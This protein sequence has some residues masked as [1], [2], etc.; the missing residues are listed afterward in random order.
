MGCLGVGLGAS[1]SCS[2]SSK[3]NMVYSMLN[4][5]DGCLMDLIKNKMSTIS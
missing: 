2:T 3:I 4:L 1:R 5:S